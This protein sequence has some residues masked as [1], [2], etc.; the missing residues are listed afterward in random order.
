MAMS[1]PASEANTAIPAIVPDA[2]DSGDLACPVLQHQMSPAANGRC[3]VYAVKVSSVSMPQAVLTFASCHQ[4]P[5][6][7]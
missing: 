3:S 7:Y 1:Q 2:E 5:F 4:F 6:R